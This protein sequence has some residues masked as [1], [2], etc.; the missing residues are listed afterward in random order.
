MPED[1]RVGTVLRSILIW[2][3]IVVGGP[4]LLGRLEPAES[5]PFMAFLVVM[6]ETGAPEPPP[7]FFEDPPPRY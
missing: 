4:L 6:P 7:S 2:I 1:W 3:A 5:L